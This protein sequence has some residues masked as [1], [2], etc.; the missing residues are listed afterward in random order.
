MQEAAPMHKLRIAMIGLK[1]IPAVW[2]GIEKY[3]EE[4]GR[5]LAQR[6]H[7]VT[8][9]GSAWYVPAATGRRYRGMRVR[10]VP[11]IRRK[12]TD[13]LTNGLCAAAAAAV[14]SFD[15]VQFHGYASYYFV[16]LVRR[17]GK[18]TVVTAHGVES[19]WDNPKYGPLARRI[20]QTAFR[21]GV[22]RA[23]CVT[24]VAAHL[25]QR[26]QRR[27]RVASRVLP[28]GLDE[29]PPA[30]PRLIRQKYDLHGR[31]YLLFLGRIDPIKRV[32]WLPDLLPRIAPQIRIVVAGGPQDASTREYYREIVRRCTGRS[33]MVFTGPVT[34]LEKAELL[35]NCLLF[36]A[37]SAYEGLPI[38]LLEA[39]AYGRCCVA[40]DI[41]AHSEVIDAEQT[42]FLFA[43]N[44]R[45]GFIELVR[46][47]TRRPVDELI[48]AGTEAE[49]R[50]RHKFNWEKTASQTENLFQSLVNHGH[51]K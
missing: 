26:L 43:P 18:I 25:Q 20:I 15:L 2:G 12:A 50:A 39:T 8:V 49:I 37:P 42:G 11:T 47:L 46:G 10:R 27:F 5:I 40:S 1:G 38:T 22:R 4:I 23:D 3:V 30:P 24:T 45:R 41:P 19:G 16:P 32:H 48:A 14:S 29:N 17:L 36:L 9:F 6:G 35:S 31:D 28:S 34:G 33:R 51:V 13:A 7:A 21:I 44:D